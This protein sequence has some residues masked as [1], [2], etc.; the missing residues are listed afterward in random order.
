M[1]GELVAGQKGK[2]DEIG[3][4]CTQ[5]SLDRRPWALRVWLRGLI[6]QVECGESRAGVGGIS[7]GGEVIDGKLSHT[8]LG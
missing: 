5:D 3:A 4:V 2:E 7:K 6:E 1:V 8:F